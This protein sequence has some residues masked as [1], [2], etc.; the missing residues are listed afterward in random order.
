M[1]PK[2]NRLTGSQVEETIKNGRFFG[3]KTLAARA[4]SSEKHGF[5][6][7]I[8]KKKLK[9]S[10][11]RHRLRRIVYSHLSATSPNVGLVVFFPQPE[12]AQVPPAERQII[13]DRLLLRISSLPPTLT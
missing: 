12:F 11:M 3:E 9:T 6:V 10:V 13:I 8:S 1:L 5:A 4:V 7:V 2:K